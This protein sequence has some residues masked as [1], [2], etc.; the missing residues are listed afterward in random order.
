MLRLLL[1]LAIAFAQSQAHFHLHAAAV[2]AGTPGHGI[3][4]SWF[5]RV[6]LPVGIGTGLI[7]LVLWPKRAGAW[8][9]ATSVALGVALSLFAWFTG[10]WMA[11]YLYGWVA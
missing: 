7:C 2:N 5:V 8:G 3:A 9:R 4:P 1:A 10:T 6:P 11:N